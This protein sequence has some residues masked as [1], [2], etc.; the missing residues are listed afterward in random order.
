MEG[1]ARI[2]FTPKQKMSSGSGG[3][4]VNVW[5]TSLKRLRGGTRAASIGSWL[6]MEELLQH[7]AGELR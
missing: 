6:S 4:A 3:R 1:T 2:R 7:R 5:R